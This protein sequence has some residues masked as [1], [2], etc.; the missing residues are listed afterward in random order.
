MV[1]TCVDLSPVIGASEVVVSNRRWW[2][3]S[4]PEAKA[5]TVALC[6]Y[7]RCYVRWLSRLR[8]DSHHASDESLF[9]RKRR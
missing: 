8:V 5:I 6:S 3:P 2:R 4:I 7:I 1:V 9:V